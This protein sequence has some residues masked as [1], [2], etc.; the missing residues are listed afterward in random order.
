MTH[1]IERA[2]VGA[3]MADGD[4]YEQVRE[5]VSPDG[6]SDHALG[7]AWQACE[8]LYERGAGIDT[9]TVG[10]ELE[11][12]GNIGQL[13]IGAW[14]GRALLGWLRDEGEPD[15]A[16]SYAEAVQDYAN[17]RQ[18][19]LFFQKCVYWAK[20]GR[21]SADIM[22]D[23]ESELSKI[24]IYSAQDE[25]TVPIGVG[26]S[27]AYDWTD[28]A[29]R[30]EV[31]GI[32]TGYIDLDR[33]IGSMIAGNVYIVGGR[34]GDGKT[35]LLLSIARNAARSGKR[36]GLF[37]LEMSRMQVAQRLIALE[38]EIDL[39]NIIQGKM[40]DADWPRYTSAVELVE[41]YPITIN[42]LSSI[43]I[44]QIRQ[45]A[46]KIKARGGLDLIV[47]DYIQLAESGEKQRERR[48]LDVSAVSRGL[49][50]LARELD[51]PV[52]AAAQLSR[53]VDQRSDKR[54]I[55]SDLRESG[56]LEQD[57]Y[58]VM[59][60]YKQNDESR[61]NVYELI[62]AKHRNGPTNTVELIWR[63]GLAKFENAV[64][65]IFRPNE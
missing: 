56:S 54:P 45:T 22:K 8:S 33:I 29:S 57:A 52:L 1:D 64:T 55:L 37:S 51:V 46:R 21:R 60:L 9:V 59:F 61:Q 25:Y 19:D 26:V 4:I 24:T 14:S 34:P 27:E 15:N 41:S 65:K 13:S 62:V 39:Q 17:K 12:T 28:R 2:L 43:N 47:L 32:P 58:C 7:M 40:K 35:A 11:R 30:G 48:E 16:M 38:S 50:Y 3:V 63:G 42:D 5:I 31:V 53:A 10:D 44:H 18:M 20:N 49:K 36:V 23:V 6:F